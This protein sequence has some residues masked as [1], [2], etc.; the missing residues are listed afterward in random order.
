[1][2]LDAEDLNADGLPDG[3][4]FRRGSANGG[5]SK[6]GDIGM[7]FFNYFPN[8]Q[9]GKAVL[10]WE[11]IWVQRL[12]EAVN[13]YQTIIMV[14]RESD[15]S[16]AGT[17]PWRE[18]NSLI[19]IGNYGEKLFAEDISSLTKEGN[20]WINSEKV[21]VSSVEMPEGFYIA[22]YEFPEVVDSPFKI[23]DGHWEGE[24]AEVLVFSSKLSEKERRGIEEYL[25]RKWISGLSY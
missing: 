5:K 22:T 17:A 13:N 16:S 25:Y 24:I 19:G 21:E 7:H 8:A 15:F 12:S 9:N 23:T 3:S 10:S 20:V 14:R 6:A 18:L 11:T 4:L 1:M 2:W